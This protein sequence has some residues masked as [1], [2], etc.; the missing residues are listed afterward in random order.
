MRTIALSAV[1]LDVGIS[2]LARGGFDPIELAVSLVRCA[3]FAQLLLR[4]GS[5]IVY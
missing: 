2:N 3:D 5:T 1:I 4:F